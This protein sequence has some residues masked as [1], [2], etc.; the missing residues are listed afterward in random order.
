VAEPLRLSAAEAA[1]SVAQDDSASDAC[2]LEVEVVDS[3]E[4]PVTQG[5]VLLEWAGGVPLEVAIDE[6]GRARFHGAGLSGALRATARSDA[7]RGRTAWTRDETAK[8]ERVRVIVAPAGLVRA[9]VLGLD[10]VPVAGIYVALSRP[11]ASALRWSANRGTAGLGP[12]FGFGLLAD[13]ALTDSRGEVEFRGVEPGVQHTLRA[14]GPGSLSALPN[15]TVTAEQGPPFTLHDL[16]LFE[17]VGLGLRVFD[18]QTGDTLPIETYGPVP[19][20]VTTFRAQ[21]QVASEIRGREQQRWILPFLPGLAERL[22]ADYEPR[23]FLLHQRVDADG[24]ETRDG[25]S[26]AQGRAE[27][28]LQVSQVLGPVDSGQ[29]SALWPAT[30]EDLPLLHLPLAAEEDFTGWID[31]EI[32]FAGVSAEVFRSCRDELGVTAYRLLQNGRLLRHAFLPWAQGPKYAIGPLPYGSYQLELRGT[33]GWR[34]PARDY[35]NIEVGPQ[36][37]VLPLEVDAGS[38]YLRPR[39]VDGQIWNGVCAITLLAPNAEWT[40]SL[41]EFSGRLFG[42]PYFEE[43]GDNWVPGV[44]AGTYIVSAGSDTR[45]ADGQRQLIVVRT[46]EVTHVDLVLAPMARPPVALPH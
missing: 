6:S 43:G 40:G 13:V 8:T 46:G 14:F 19:G 31:F 10:D 24:L 17:V 15:S 7:G 2:W 32:Q 1:R 35:A 5:T 25:V 23:F 3:A 29:V 33:F 36:R 45:F 30:A 18:P 27:L 4:L 41:D 42:S 20:G 37:E 11:E 39:D 22:G 21:P 12:T 16:P 44:P 9:R 28:E 38:L 34:Y 26:W